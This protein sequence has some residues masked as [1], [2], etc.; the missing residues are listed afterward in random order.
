MKK[1]VL[2]FVAFV[3]VCVSTD[4]YSWSF[5]FKRSSFRSFFTRFCFDSD[6]DGYGLFCSKG[7]DCNDSNS[8]IN[9]GQEEIVY[10]GLDNDCNSATYDDDLDRAGFAK[11]FD[12]DD[13]DFSVG[14]ICPVEEE[15]VVEEEVEVDPEPEV[16]EEIIENDLGLAQIMDFDGRFG[17]VISDDLPSS[18]EPSG[19]VFHPEL[20]TYFIVSD[21]G[22]LTEITN[23][24]EVV[25][26]IYLGGDLEAVTLNEKVSHKL[27]IGVENPDSIIE[28]DLDQKKVTRRFD[29]TGIMT[30]ASNQGLEALTFVADDSHPEGGEFYA[31]LQ[32]TGQIFVFELPL[33]DSQSQVVVHVDTISTPY[34]DLSGM[35]YEK[36]MDVIYAIYD[37]RNTMLILDVDGNVLES[38]RLPGNDQEGITLDLEGNLLIAEDVGPEVLIYK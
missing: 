38:H 33:Q 37:S 22:Y 29:L 34:S 25:Q 18:Y 7:Q 32:Q 19:A 3:F 4:A 35:Q 13:Q 20:G 21:G 36:G 31:G 24:G 11:A 10:D 27:Y 28:Y 26:N 30:G 6:K 15:V 1:I 16:E 2:L 8:L 23:A 12:C 17:E 9:P 14:D 5:S